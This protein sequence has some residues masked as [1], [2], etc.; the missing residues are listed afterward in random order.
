M[1][2]CLQPPC[3]K[4]YFYKIDDKSN[5]IEE[6][7]SH[8][9]NKLKSNITIINNY[10]NLSDSDGHNAENRLDKLI[11]FLENNVDIID[12]KKNKKPEIIKYNTFIITCSNTKRKICRQY[13]I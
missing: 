13:T 10:M 2:S 4:N 8:S 6:E 12:E 5:E 3:L 9:N 1:G 7:L 11:K